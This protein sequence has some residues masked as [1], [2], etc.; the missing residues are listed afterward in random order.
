[1]KKLFATFVFLSLILSAAA[2]RP[3]YI[4]QTGHSGPVTVL[5]YAASDDVL[6]SG[7]VDGTIKVWNRETHKI[8]FADRI[9]PDAIRLLALHPDKP[10]FA[11]V[12][13]RDGVS[14]VHCGDWRRGTTLYE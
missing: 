7:G 8:L 14:T 10:I 3:R 2:G 5:E 12:S 1:M 9:S 11:A 13:E 6:V 4:I